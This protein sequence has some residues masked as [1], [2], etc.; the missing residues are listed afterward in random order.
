MRMSSACCTMRTRSRRGTGQ[1]LFRVPTPRAD[2]PRERLRMGES[3]AGYVDP[4]NELI[5]L[6]ILG[7]DDVDRRQQRGH[8]REQA[9]VCHGQPRTDSAP[10]AERSG[11]RIPHGWIEATVRS[12]KPLGIEA[13][14]LGIIVGVL[15]NGPNPISVMESIEM[16]EHSPSGS[17]D[18]GAF[19][20]EVS[21]ILVILGCSAGNAY[22]SCQ[23]RA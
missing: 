4:R 9:R 6:R 15:E 11:P 2:R 3:A 21:L 23:H 14:G 20:N 7:T 12:Q 16:I 5:A 13:L 19:R 22:I 8:S 10:P 17:H 18:N 1:Q